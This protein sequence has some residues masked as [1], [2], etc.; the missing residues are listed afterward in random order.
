MSKLTRT[1]EEVLQ[2]WEDL[3]GVS[4]QEEISA[5]DFKDETKRPAN[6]KKADEL[7]RKILRHPEGSAEEL[8]ELVEIFGI[9]AGLGRGLGWLLAEQVGALANE[10]KNEMNDS[11]QTVK[12]PTMATKKPVT[13]KVVET[14][15]KEPIVTESAE[16]T[17]LPVLPATPEQKALVEKWANWMEVDL[18]SEISLM[19]QD[20]RSYEGRGTEILRLIAS[21]MVKDDPDAQGLWENDLADLIEA[22]GVIAG[23][24]IGTRSEWSTFCFELFRKVEVELK[25]VREYDE[26]R[27][28]VHDFERVKISAPTLELLEELELTEAE[29]IEI[30]VRAAMGMQKGKPAQPSDILVLYNFSQEEL[31]NFGLLPQH[32]TAIRERIVRCTPEEL[33]FM[34]GDFPPLLQRK[35]MGLMNG[36]DLMLID[37]LF[38]EIG[39]FVDDL[40]SKGCIEGAFNRLLDEVLEHPPECMRLRLSSRLLEMTRDQMVRLVRELCA[41]NLAVGDPEA[42]QTL[43]EIVAVEG[44]EDLLTKILAEDGVLFSLASLIREENESRGNLF[45]RFLQGTSSTGFYTQANLAVEVI[46]ECREE[47]KMALFGPIVSNETES[48]N[49]VVTGNSQNEEN[50]VENAIAPSENESNATSKKENEVNILTSTFGPLETYTNNRAV[51]SKQQQEANKICGAINK[52]KKVVPHANRAVL[53]EHLKLLKDALDGNITVDGKRVQARAIIGK[54]KELANEFNINLTPQKSKNGKRLIGYIATYRIADAKTKGADMAT[55]DGE[56]IVETENIV[57]QAEEI[58]APEGAEGEEEVV[59]ENNV[60]V[61]EEGAVE[62]KE[63]ENYA[64]GNGFVDTLCVKLDDAGNAVNRS[65]QLRKANQLTENEDPVSQLVLSSLS[66][67]SADKD[68]PGFQAEYKDSVAATKFAQ[69]QQTVCKNLGSGNG[70]YRQYYLE[71][72]TKEQPEGVSN[73]ITRCFQ[74]TIAV[75]FL[76]AH[77]MDVSML[78]PEVVANGLAAFGTKS[79]DKI[80][81]KTI[82]QL[83][84]SKGRNQTGLLVQINK[85]RQLLAETEKVQNL[86]KGEKAKLIAYTA[87]MDE[88]QRIAIE[89]EALVFDRSS[90]KTKSETVSSE[91]LEAVAKTLAAGKVSFK[92]KNG[93]DQVMNLFVTPANAGD[94]RERMAHEFVSATLQ[95]L[96]GAMGQTDSNALLI[97]ETILAI[98]QT[99]MA[100]IRGKAVWYLQVAGYGVVQGLCGALSITVG[101]VSAVERLLVSGYCYIRSLFAKDGDKETWRGH[102]LRHIKAVGNRLLDVVRRPWNALVS[103]IT[104]KKEGEEGTK[105]GLLSCEG[106]RRTKD[107]GEQEHMAVAVAMAIPRAIYK[108]GAAICKGIGSLFSFFK[109]DKAEEKKAVTEQPTTESVVIT[110]A[111]PQTA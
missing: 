45:Q 61:L 4:L 62:V 46:L 85:R 81:S 99:R 64:A 97:N 33:Q 72:A 30:V 24:E 52:V 31:E 35:A 69:A 38:E 32:S 93:K 109:K 13:K 105:N 29:A 54:L 104:G 21:A 68:K 37:P 48:E 91:M 110:T 95:Y 102:A 55:T 8:A 15:T 1:Q 23:I 83:V 94:R 42:G 44:C 58:T 59:I 25:G 40:D 3:L 60:E 9:V 84:K 100:K 47:I 77:K 86:S 53:G 19:K 57:A 36:N 78:L 14:K 7:A 41:G 107:D 101:V 16:P 103:L 22:V 34:E 67:V 66:V 80:V 20:P 75:M 12:E 5:F 39:D 111:N 26:A 96:Q 63:K 28:L 106:W 50:V 18:D 82:A 11:K 73:A 43:R 89:K 70:G 90:G 51:T 49:I 87:I 98:T 71:L 88:W 108:T 17:V 76:T 10:V 27:A 56:K 92:D 79:E 74:Q 65:L 6:D 2:K